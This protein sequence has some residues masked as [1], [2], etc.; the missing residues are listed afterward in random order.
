MMWGFLPL[1]WDLMP[2]VD[3]LTLLA[4]RIIWAAAITLVLLAASGRLSELSAVYRSRATM[5]Y[6][7]PATLL[8]LAD[9]GWYIVGVKSGRVLD[10][11]LG[12]FMNP[13]VAFV[14]G[15]II[16]KEHCRWPKYL[17]VGLAAV[18]VLISAIGFGRFP[19]FSIIIAFVWA[20]YG[21]SMKKVSLSAAISFGAQVVLMLPLA[22]IFL[23][24]FRTGENSVQPSGHSLFAITLFYIGGGAATAVPM[25]MYSRCVTKVPLSTIGFFQYLSPTCNIIAGLILGELISVDKWVS[26]AFIWCGIAVFSLSGLLTRRGSTDRST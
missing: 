24:I 8:L 10:I 3:S 14:L 1:Y 11:S 16:F 26:F 6:L 19:W 12:Y 13:L 20:F 4:M 23:L 15:L 7:A 2:E 18:G 17:A 25:L 5:K 9:W 21:V 22:I